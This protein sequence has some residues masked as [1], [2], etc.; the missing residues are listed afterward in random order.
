MSANIFDTTAPAY[1]AQRYIHE[2]C[3]DL[4]DTSIGFD[5]LIVTRIPTGWKW[6]CHRC[7]KAGFKPVKGLSPKET[8]KFIE[9]TKVVE[10]KQVGSI[11]LPDDFS[12]YIP[13][14]GLMWLYKYITDEDIYYHKI[15]YS[16]TLNRVIFPVYEGTTL[17]CWQGRYLGKVDA[18]HPKYNTEKQ[19]GSKHIY[20]KVVN[21]VVKNTTVVLVEDYMSAIKVGNFTDCWAL[22]GSYIPDD[23]MYILKKEYTNVVIWLDA[24]MLKAAT[25]YQKRFFMFGV[26]CRV[27]YSVQDPKEYSLGEIERRLR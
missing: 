23:L 20:F 11:L 13:E 3:P 25:K 24:N 2:G 5:S 22:L 4:K 27:Y 7:K 21:E 19:K 26:P 6:F 8:L 15:G 18:Y 10:E 9:S 1:V 17:V 14:E 16:T 12:Y